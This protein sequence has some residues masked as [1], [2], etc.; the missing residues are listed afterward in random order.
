MPDNVRTV[1]GKAKRTKSLGTPDKREALRVISR[2][3]LTEEH[4]AEIEAARIK[5]GK[6]DPLSAL[7]DDARAEVQNAGGVSGFTD[8][9]EREP[10]AAASCDARSR[11][12]T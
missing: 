11:A 12:L 8:W 4:D 2:L 10:S 1:V 5:S 3:R 6:I 7:N 9:L